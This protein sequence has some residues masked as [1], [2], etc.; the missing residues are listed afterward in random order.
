MQRAG[1]LHGN[2]TMHAALVKSHTPEQAF[3]AKIEAFQSG[4]DADRVP[5]VVLQLL[6][7]EEKESPAGV[8]VVAYEQPLETLESFLTSASGVNMYMAPVDWV[9]V[10]F[11]STRA[12]VL[13]AEHVFEIPIAKC[14]CMSRLAYDFVHALW[15]A[16]HGQSSWALHPRTWIHFARS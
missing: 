6:G 12:T 5:H 13:A 14:A 10:S 2:N 11:R 1:V 8:V 4:E 16:H 15:H 3:E 9:C 7:V